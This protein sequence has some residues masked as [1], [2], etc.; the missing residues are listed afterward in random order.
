MTQVHIPRSS[1]LRKSFQGQLLA[2]SASSWNSL[3]AD[4]SSLAARI[5]VSAA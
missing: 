3:I 1:R 4:F 2:G 5:A